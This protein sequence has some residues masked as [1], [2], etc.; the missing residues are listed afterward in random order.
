MRPQ[1]LAIVTAAALVSAAG[2]EPSAAADATGIK[3]SGIKV[4][5]AWAR[6][7][8]GQGTS[9]AIY[10]TIVNDGKTDDRLTGVTTPVA[11]RAELHTMLPEGGIMRMRTLETMDIEAGATVSMIPSDGHIM[12]IGLQ[13]PL[14]EG[15]SFPVTLT[16]EKAGNVEATV[17]VVKPDAM[18]PPGADEDNASQENEA[19]MHGAG[20]GT[21]ADMN[22]GMGS[23][24]NHPMPPMPPMEHGT[25]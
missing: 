12:L 21:G 5:N 24:P 2:T 1:L 14:K 15:D 3:A 9:G 7:S 10:V 6:A 23:D 11:A 20:H 17:E 18:G 25:Y 4:E 16:F 19:D 13:G 22:H 8:I